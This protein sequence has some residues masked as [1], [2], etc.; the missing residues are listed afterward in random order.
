MILAKSSYEVQDV[1]PRSKVLL[2]VSNIEAG[3]VGILIVARSHGK[4]K[5]TAKIYAAKGTAE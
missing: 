4:M 5:L 3:G 1:T 2:T